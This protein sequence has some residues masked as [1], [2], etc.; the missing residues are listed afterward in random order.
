MRTSIRDLSLLTPSRITICLPNDKHCQLTQL[1]R[2]ADVALRLIRSGAVGITPDD[3]PAGVHLAGIVHTLRNLGLPIETTRE[4]APR[5]AFG[6]VR[7]RYRTSLTMAS[8]V[9]KPQAF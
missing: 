4:A 8:F 6:A 5:D 7:A 1:T 2:I 3:F 9:G